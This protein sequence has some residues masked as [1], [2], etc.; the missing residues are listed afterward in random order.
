MSSQF[1][2]HFSSGLNWWWRPHEDIFTDSVQLSHT[3]DHSH[4][5]MAFG[6]MCSFPVFYSVGLLISLATNADQL[7]DNSST[8][9]ICQTPKSASICGQSLSS[10]TLSPFTPDPRRI[11]FHYLF[12]PVTRL[13]VLTWY[14]WHQ[15]E[16]SEYS[17][18]PQSL[19]IEACC[20]PSNRSGAV[21]FRGL[22]QDCA[23]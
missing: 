2:K 12:I 13:P 10:L 18:G 15:P 16:G 3:F 4:T 8:F 19:D 23:E 17:E 5:Y 11:I 6:H 21:P 20:L 22:L 1:L 9:L 7:T 14:S